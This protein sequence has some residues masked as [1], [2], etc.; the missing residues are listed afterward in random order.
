MF[1]FAL[2]RCP[3]NMMLQKIELLECT[4]GIL[5]DELYVVKQHESLSIDPRPKYPDPVKIL[6]LV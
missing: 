4:L 5:A 1:Q 2:I 6:S 3:R